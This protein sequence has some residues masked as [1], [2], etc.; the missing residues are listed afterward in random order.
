MEL[1]DEFERLVR[2]LMEYMR[3]DAVEHVCST[4]RMNVVSTPKGFIVHILSG[5]R[6]RYTVLLKRGKTEVIDWEVEKVREVDRI[7]EALGELGGELDACIDRYIARKEDELTKLRTV[8]AL[9]DL[10]S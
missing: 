9:L 8:L 2:K 5:G 7:G 3:H 4:G 1:R 10:A 6:T